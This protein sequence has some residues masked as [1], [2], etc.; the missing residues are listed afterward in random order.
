MINAIVVIAVFVVAM[1]DA[2]SIGKKVLV[3]ADDRAR[4]VSFFRFR[5]SRENVEKRTQTFH[6]LFCLVLIIRS[7]KENVN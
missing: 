3:N 5:T 2:S 1:T 4:Y 6:L 7:Q